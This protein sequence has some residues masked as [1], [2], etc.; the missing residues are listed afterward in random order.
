MLQL[1]SQGISILL[2]VDGIIASNA[3][4]WIL[5]LEMS[6]ENMDWY[7]SVLGYEK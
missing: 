5:Y 6:G 1:F 4:I 3:S 2:T 7:F